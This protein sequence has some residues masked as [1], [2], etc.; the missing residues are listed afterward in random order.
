MISRLRTLLTCICVL[1]LAVGVARAQDEGDLA[2]EPGPAV[3][4]AAAAAGEAARPF[5]PAEA[6][7]STS[8][9][10]LL[11]DDFTDPAVGVLPRSSPQPSRYVRGYVDGEYMIRKPESESP[12]FFSASPDPSFTDVTIQVDARLEG[13]PSGR[14]YVMCRQGAGPSGYELAV[15][16]TTGEFRLRRT[17]AGQAVVLVN[18]TRSPA[19]SRGNASNHIELTCAGNQ[20]GA[21]V[22]GSAVARVRDDNYAEG[23]IALGAGGATTAVDARFASLRVLAAMDAPAAPPPS[24]TPTR[25]PAT[26]TPT[27]FVNALGTPVP[28]PAPGEGAGARGAG[29]LDLTNKT[30]QELVF[31][32]VKTSGSGPSI[33]RH[34]SAGQRAYVAGIASGSYTLMFGLGAS[35]STVTSRLT[36]DRMFYQF[37]NPIQWSQTKSGDTT[38]YQDFTLALDDALVGKA[39]PIDEDLFL[40]S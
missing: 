28:T 22:N 23:R 1:T 32:L 17:D 21:S 26:P 15:S 39:G 14:V 40:R 16:P 31:K 6:P 18:L 7:P 24:A 3:E 27:P 25:G 37:A 20:I 29:V 4:D 19:I 34:L 2:T 38:V 11:A 35:Y 12:D 13:E 10:T 36:G 30:S 5:T 8:D 33:F 9:P